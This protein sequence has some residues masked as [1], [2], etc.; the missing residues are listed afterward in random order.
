LILKATLRPLLP[1]KRKKDL[2]RKDM[3]FEVGYFFPECLRRSRNGFILPQ[4]TSV[5]N[6]TQRALFWSLDLIL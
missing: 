3:N 1:S 4:E 5:N 2:E 6:Y